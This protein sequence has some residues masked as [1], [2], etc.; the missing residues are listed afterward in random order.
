[1]TGVTKTLLVLTI[2]NFVLGL[3]FVTGALSVGDAPALYVTLPAGAICFGL[4][5][6]WHMLEKETAAY[7]EEQRAHRS[8]PLPA[9][10]PEPEYDHGQHSP[11][12][13]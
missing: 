6:I 5:L 7:D 2:V 4:F 9:A 8:P 12:R 3:L 1:M 13:A 11:S 10:H